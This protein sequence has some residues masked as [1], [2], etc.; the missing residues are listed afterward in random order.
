MRY[1][2]DQFHMGW[3]RL[4]IGKYV[5]LQCNFEGWG[6]FEISL[7]VCNLPYCKGVFLKLG[8]IQFGLVK[9]E[10][11]HGRNNCS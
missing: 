4:L 11:F 6:L 7:E 9:H 2:V 10:A 8:F 3:C 5:T 1:A